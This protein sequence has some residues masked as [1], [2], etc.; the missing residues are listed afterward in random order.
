MTLLAYF[1][2]CSPLTENPNEVFPLRVDS[3]SKYLAEY[4]QPPVP[5]KAKG[6]PASDRDVAN[7]TPEEPKSVALKSAAEGAHEPEAEQSCT[8]VEAAV[9]PAAE[10]AEESEAERSSTPIGAAVEPAAAAEAEAAAAEPA[11]EPAAKSAAKAVAEPTAALE[12]TTSAVPE[13]APRFRLGKSRTGIDFNEETPTNLVGESHYGYPIEMTVPM[14]V[15][16]NNANGGSPPGIVCDTTCDE[17][18]L[19]RLV[20]PS[21]FIDRWNKTCSE[22]NKVK[23]LDRICK[24]AAVASA[25]SSKEIEAALSSSGQLTLSLEHPGELKVSVKKG[26][27]GLGLKCKELE[28]KALLIESISDGIIKEMNESGAIRPPIKPYD[29]VFQVN[30]KNDYAD[31]MLIKME[32]SEDFTMLVYS[33]KV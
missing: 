25:Q 17:L 6:D 9:E 30:G 10:A 13:P 15:I 27:K 7:E 23:K 32:S 24:V 11:A 5:P 1:A 21:G 22:Q 14:T 16:V 29:V 3:P 33:Y 19:V 26:G 4:S 18:C 12:P 28:G 8:P 31:E 20:N 2:C